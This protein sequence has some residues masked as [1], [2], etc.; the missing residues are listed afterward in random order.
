MLVLRCTRKLLERVGPPGVAAAPSTTALG[1]WYAQPVSVGRQRFILLASEHS[2]LAVLMPGRD[3]MRECV[4]TVTNSRSVLG[5]LNDYAHILQFWVHPDPDIDLVEVALRLSET[6]S[7]PLG[8]E[9]PG[10]VTLQLLG[11]AGRPA[12]DQRPTPAPQPTSHT[13]T[14]TPTPQERPT[15]R[16]PRPALHRIIARAERIRARTKG[17]SGDDLDRDEV[18]GRFVL[19]DLAEI[20]RAVAG[21]PAEVRALQPQAPWHGLQAIGWTTETHLVPGSGDSLLWLADE[22]LDKLS[23]AAQAIIAELDARGIVAPARVQEALAAYQLRLSLKGIRPPI[24]RRLVV[25]NDIT[26]RRLHNIIQVAGDWWNY[27]LHEFVVT[28]MYYGRPDPDGELPHM[29]DAH[30]RLR[31]LPLTE[32]EVFEY[33]YDFGD[34]WGIDILLEKVLPLEEASGPARCLGGARAFPHE[35]AGGVSGYDLL[36]E[37]LAD[38]AHEEHESY[39]TWAGDWQPEAFDLA[40]TN[41]RLVKLG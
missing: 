10:D 7:G 37:A 6:P 1:D 27:H 12:G 5:S 28:G 14:P 32:G 41:R 17:L 35:D 38:P 24:W 13:P 20:G 34:H 25:R 9:R 26:L 23:T 31:N 3:A 18:L 4:I 21:F 33:V 2:R 19:R 15:V 39:R 16:N 8:Y 30:V 36:C 40:E 11:A 29:S 22:Y